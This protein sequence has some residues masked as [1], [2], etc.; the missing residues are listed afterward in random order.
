MT[1]RIRAWLVAMLLG[2]ATLVAAG[3][4]PRRVLTVHS[5][6]S[7]SPPFTTHSIAFETKL[8]GKL[9]EPVDLDEILLDE[10]RYPELFAFRRRASEYD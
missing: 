3:A 10:A 4:N 2:L 7:V 9:G 8:T 1:G 6:G 5:F